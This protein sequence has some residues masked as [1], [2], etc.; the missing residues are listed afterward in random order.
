MLCTIGLVKLVGL[1][2]QIVNTP[3]YVV[4]VTVHTHTY[5]PTFL[6]LHLYAMLVHIIRVHIVAVLLNKPGRPPAGVCYLY[7]LFHTTATLVF[8]MS[9]HFL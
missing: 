1:G 2:I 7:Y 8:L 4:W 6:V 5:V 9:A 3:Q